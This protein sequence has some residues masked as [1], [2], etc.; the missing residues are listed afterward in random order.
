[1]SKSAGISVFAVATVG[2]SKDELKEAG[3]DWV[4]ASLKELEAKVE[5][6]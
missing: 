5:T 3:A 2:N 1:M 4:L 6:L